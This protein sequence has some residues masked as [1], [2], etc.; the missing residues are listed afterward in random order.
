[1]GI[2][3]VSKGFTFVLDN[4]KHSLVR[5]RLVG[6][7]REQCGKVDNEGQRSGEQPPAGHSKQ[8]RLLHKQLGSPCNAATSSTKSTG[9]LVFIILGARIC[10]QCNY[11]I[12]Y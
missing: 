9:T 4:S 7:C 8:L 10:K 2:G 5:L 11:I 6:S 3:R 1:M 12:S